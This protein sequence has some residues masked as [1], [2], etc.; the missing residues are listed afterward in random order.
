MRKLR[1][2]TS[3]WQ[4]VALEKFKEVC[5]KKGYDVAGP[6]DAAAT[7]TPK[8]TVPTYSPG[9]APTSVTSTS[10]PTTQSS[11]ASTTS[12]AS[13]IASASA[14]ASRSMAA[15]ESMAASGSTTATG[16]ASTSGAAGIRD[17]GIANAAIVIVIVWL[18]FSLAS[19][20][21]MVPQEHM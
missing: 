5:A 9:S 12:S 10:Q 4:I 1:T 16:G 14:T 6:A 13:A 3:G 19:R 2:L 15:S 21:Q 17:G 11:Q 20:L 18:A 7:V 8:G